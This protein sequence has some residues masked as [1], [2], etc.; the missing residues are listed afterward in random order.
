MALRRMPGYDISAAATHSRLHP[1]D[2]DSLTP[3][4]RSLLI[5]WIGSL[6]GPSLI[7]IHTEGWG[8]AQKR[9]SNSSCIDSTL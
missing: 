5:A 9:L 7:D 4:K 2:S 8:W 6:Q 3:P 1:T